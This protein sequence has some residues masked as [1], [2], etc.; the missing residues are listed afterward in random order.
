MPNLLVILFPVSNFLEVPKSITLRSASGDSD[1]KSRFSG[2]KSLCTIFWLWQ[3]QTALSIYLISSAAFFSLKK[4]ILFIRSNSSPPEQ[5]LSSMNLV[6]TR[7]PNNNFY[8]LRIIHTILQC[9]DG[10][11][12]SIYSFLKTIFLYLLSI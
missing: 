7:L 6:L 8:H 3:Y 2:F 4:F 5:Y 10:L 11:N 9:V 1:T 12:T